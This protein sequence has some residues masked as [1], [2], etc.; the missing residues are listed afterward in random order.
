M[1]TEQIF[2]KRHFRKLKKISNQVIIYLFIMFQEKGTV[3]SKELFVALNHL[4]LP[5]KI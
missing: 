1:L 2:L 4:F 5:L 3:I